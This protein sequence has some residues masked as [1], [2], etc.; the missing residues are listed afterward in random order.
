MYAETVTLCS[1]CS[2]LASLSLPQST[3]LTDVC[4]CL[5]GLSLSV[6]QGQK[7]APW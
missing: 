2:V 5:Q 1:L 6:T 7:Q 3:E 4:A